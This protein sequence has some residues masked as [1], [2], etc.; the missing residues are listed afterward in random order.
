MNMHIFPAPY[1]GEYVSECMRGRVR[2]ER[3]HLPTAP[4]AKT[5]V[6]AQY[7]TSVQQSKSLSRYVESL[8]QQGFTP[9][10]VS[11]CPSDAPL[12][13]PHG[14]VGDCLI[15]RR[16]NLG[17]DFGSWSTALGLIPAI[18]RSDIVLLTNDSMLGPFDDIGHLIDWICEP[19]P[20]IRGLTTSYQMARHLQSYFV[21]FRGGILD[22][23]PWRD[24]FNAIRV[25]PTKED[26]VLAYE[27]G[28][29][30][31]AIAEG[32]SFDEWITG[33]DLGYMYA[34][35]T[36]DGWQKLLDAGVPM[37][38]KMLFT[39]EAFVDD[40]PLIRDELRQRF[41]IDVDQ[42]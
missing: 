7:S 1:E 35:P 40:V 6:I 33:P 15:I 9:I 19:G 3:G 31:R 39:H 18:R 25:L 37:V 4:P 28:L 21:A 17:Y 24:F 26:V 13:F 12:E 32:Y 41:N 27:M 14:L 22:D 34:N 11:T 42:W 30:R 2:L 38:K 16:P 5:A 8:S 36:T 23:R 10:I 20:D 29:T